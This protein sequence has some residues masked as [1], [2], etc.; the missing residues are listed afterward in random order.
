MIL[1]ISVIR[2][3]TQNIILMTLLYKII[4][5]SYSDNIPLANFKKIH[6]E[7][8]PRTIFA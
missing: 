7:V 8:L 1:S 5:H 6:G 2:K 4:G 3:N